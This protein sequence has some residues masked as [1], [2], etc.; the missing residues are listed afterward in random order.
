MEKILFM[1]LVGIVTV[2]LLE[3][4]IEEQYKK[5]KKIKTEVPIKISDKNVE[6][7][8]NWIQI[9]VKEFKRLGVVGDFENYYSTMSYKAEAQI[10]RNLENFF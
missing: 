5:K 2:F 10:V 4:K 7:C 6:N 3:W 9:H 1:C 8:K